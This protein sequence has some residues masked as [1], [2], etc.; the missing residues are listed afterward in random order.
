MD[1]NDPAFLEYLAQLPDDQRA[2]MFRPFMDEGAAL[3]QQLAQA[4]ALRNPASGQHSTGMGAALGGLGDVF[5]SIS[6]AGQEQVIGGQQKQLRGDMQGE[7]SS[8][9]GDY[10]KW[11]RMRGNAGPGGQSLAQAL[12]QAGAMGQQLPVMD[13]TQGMMRFFGL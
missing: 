8:R 10:A 9:A 3:D 2:A 7:A 13:D 12:P 4:R 5:R 11:L 1:F 6:G